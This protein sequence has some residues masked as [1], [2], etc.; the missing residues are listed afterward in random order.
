[1]IRADSQRKPL[2]KFREKT[3][4]NTCIVNKSHKIEHINNLPKVFEGVKYEK[5]KLSVEQTAG[6]DEKSPEK[7]KKAKYQNQ[8]K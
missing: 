5:T 4:Q 1:M 8:G 6:K 7:R 3:W 2:I